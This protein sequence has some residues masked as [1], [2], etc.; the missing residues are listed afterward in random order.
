MS[1]LMEYR[2]ERMGREL[3]KAHARIG[4]LEA[5]VG[6]DKITM[7]NFLKRIEQLEAA[8]YR[9]NKRLEAWIDCAKEAEAA[10]GGEDA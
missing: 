9:K 3:K 2:D 7:A 4:K 8:L 6:I 10:L 1:D 5:K